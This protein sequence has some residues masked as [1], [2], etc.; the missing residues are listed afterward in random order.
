[1]G[2][3]IL[4]KQNSQR[5]ESSIRPVS[6]EKRLDYSVSSLE[7]VTAVFYCFYI[8]FEQNTKDVL[9]QFKLKWPCV[10]GRKKF[11]GK[12]CIE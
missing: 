4:N 8:L 2:R 12:L 1:M 5:P 11:T 3:K 9:G 7:D 10:S 6:L